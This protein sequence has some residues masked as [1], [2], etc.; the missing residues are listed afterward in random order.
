MKQTALLIRAKMPSLAILAPSS[1]CPIQSTQIK[2][3]E[4]CWMITAYLKLLR[5]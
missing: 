5:T 1:S 2:K 3:K 4:T